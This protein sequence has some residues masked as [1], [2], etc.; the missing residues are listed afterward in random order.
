[1]RKL[2]LQMQV[3]ADGFV[4]GP[5]G[6]TGWLVWNWDEGLKQFVRSITMPV[7]HILLGRKLAE[8]FIPAWESQAKPGERTEE[9]DAVNKV[10][11]TPKTVFS[12]T[13][14][15][16]DWKNTTLAVGDFADVITKMKQ[17]PGSD[18]I[19][20]GGVDFVSSLINAGLIDEYHLFINPAAIGKGRSIFKDIN[21]QRK[22]KLVNAQS[23]ECGIVVLS[24]GPLGS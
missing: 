12:R 24:Y 23:F 17:Q 3:S 7:D 19:A 5:N 2:K 10:N 6:E 1:M 15:T 4:C 18:I 13:M 21:S 14:K 22:L 9:M 16:A 20:Y 11:N 8:G